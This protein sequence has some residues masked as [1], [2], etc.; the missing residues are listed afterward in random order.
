[1]LAVQDFDFTIRHAKSF[2]VVVPDALGRDVAPKSLCLRCYNALTNGEQ[3]GRDVEKVN[4]V[5]HA[6]IL[7][8]SPAIEKMP[9]EQRIQIGDLS[10][11]SAER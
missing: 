9:S 4:A 10:M 6:S 8:S 1:M 7:E 2:T 5:K 11:F 3:V